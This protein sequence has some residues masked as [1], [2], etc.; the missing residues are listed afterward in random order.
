[1]LRAIE[2]FIVVNC[3]AAEGITIGIEDELEEGID[4]ETTNGNEGLVTLPR[5]VGL[6]TLWNP[7]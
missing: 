6:I 4:D 1:M 7:S 2:V 5:C 3:V